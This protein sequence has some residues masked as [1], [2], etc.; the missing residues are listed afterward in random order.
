MQ[1][2]VSAKIHITAFL[3]SY[4]S[5]S[6]LLKRQEQSGKDKPFLAIVS[7]P[8]GAQAPKPDELAWNNQ[9][10]EESF[11]KQSSFFPMPE[12]VIKNSPEEALGWTANIWK[13]YSE[14]SEIRNMYQRVIVED[15][16]DSLED[17]ENMTTRMVEII[18][19]IVRSEGI[20]ENGFIKGRKL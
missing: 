14:N 4:S 17:Y 13:A 6:F 10:D 18:R 11:F 20:N 1:A 8:K 7:H 9:V 19:E 15:R 5:L 12:N 16:L 3:P 2:Q